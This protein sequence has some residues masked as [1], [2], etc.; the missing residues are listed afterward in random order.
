MKVTSVPASWLSD[1][2][3]RLAARSYTSGALEAKIM[4]SRTSMPKERLIELS[5]GFKGGVYRYPG[6]RLRR[7]WVN[8]KEH[9]VAFLGNSAMLRSDLSH[10]P[11]LS[12][13]QACSD[14]FL[15]LRLKSG[16]ILISCSGTPVRMVY[17]RS[18][19]A[20]MWAAQGIMKVR[21]DPSK[22]PPGY[23]YACLS[24]RFGVP[25]AISGTYGAIGQ[26]VERERIAEL[27]I[28]RL[29][30]AIERRVHELVDGAARKRT[31]AL[32]LLGEARARVGHLLGDSKSS[33]NAASCWTTVC[34]SSLK[35]RCDAYYFSQPCLTARKAFDEA[36]V[37]RHVLLEDVAVV[38]IPAIFK[39]RYTDDPAL[40]CPYVTAADVFHLAPAADRLLMKRVAHEFRLVVST[41]TILIQQKGQLGGLMG[42][43]VLVGECM[44]GF[45][46]AGNMIRVTAKD[47]DDTGYLYAVLTTEEGIRLLAREAA[48]S[49]NRHVEGS[50]VRRIRIPWAS[51]AVRQE[52]GQ[53]VIAARELRDEACADEEAAC[54]F[55]E[56]AI[57]EAI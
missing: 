41:N 7:I 33:P 26:H 36:R 30:D 48:G 51:Q 35:S 37:E 54:S 34:A 6:V 11:L 47:D 29:G 52:I 49:T 57:E 23:V 1:G 46:V 3:F 42:H 5:H 38:F 12:K 2:S 4:L 28:P 21:P 40:G 19:M 50:R 56:R 31:E 16:M 45:A 43:S 17:T 13:R 44:N 24:S 18:D 53:L 32:A 15:A 55:A 8:S 10:L 25:L 22:V 14:R 27:P 20:G 9:G 39:R